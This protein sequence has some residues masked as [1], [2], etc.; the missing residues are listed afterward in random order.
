MGKI[1]IY[2]GT[3]NPIHNTH[4]S[5]ADAALKQFGLD[6]IYFLITG[7]PPHKTSNVG[8]PDFCR[9]EM[10]QLAIKKYPKFEIDDREMYRSGKSYS[11]ITLSELRSE[12]PADQLY[13][14]MGSDSLLNF[15]NWV[16]PAII[17]SCATI[18]AAP[19]LGDDMTA[20]TACVDK[21]QNTY[22]GDFY[23]IDYQAND[24]ASSFIRDN[25]ENLPSVADYVPQDVLNYIADHNIYS[26][27]IYD[28]DTV[29]SLQKKMAEELKPGRFTHSVGVAHT[30]YWL[31]V[32]WNY[33]AY[34][35]QVAGMLHD[36]AKCLTDEKRISICK[37]NN[38]PISPV[39]A[40]NPS[41]LHGKVGAHLAKEKYDIRDSQIEHA[42][43]VHTTGC[44]NM[45]LLDKIIYIA[46]YIEPG[47]NKQPRLDLLRKIAF[48]DLDLCLYMILEDTVSYLDSSL[49]D[50]DQTTLDTYYYYK[51]MRE[52][53]L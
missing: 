44:P 46:D 53:K 31:A 32:K 26:S 20:I 7:Q 15:E 18:L 13:F 11:Y 22:S 6:K 42:I 1:G 37:K 35:A 51:K 23:V 34:N 25:A 50:M 43:A 10:L 4:L 5:I 47:R 45:N 38:L 2:G 21:Y 30:A 8:V 52:G 17:S 49:N 19:R 14:I 29:L 24:T 41:L 48:E 39:E 40:K 16:N 27:K 3:F 28:Y 12:H 36:C 9:L 33:P